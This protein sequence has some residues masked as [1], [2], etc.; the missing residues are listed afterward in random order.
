MLGQ[1]GG[2]AEQ[3]GREAGGAS[4]P[5]AAAAAPPLPPRALVFHPDGSFCFGVDPLRLDELAAG[6]R[7]GRRFQ[8]RSGQP[9]APRG[10]WNARWRSRICAPLLL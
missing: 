6:G 3:L 10:P 7:A 5:A 4:S 8:A 2:E 1:D 9:A